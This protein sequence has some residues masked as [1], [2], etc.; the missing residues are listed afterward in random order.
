MACR[1][2]PVL[3][4]RRSRLGALALLAM[5]AACGGGK[6]DKSDANLSSLDAR[7][8]N[9]AGSFSPSSQPQR[10][11]TGPA[12]TLGSLALSQRADTDKDDNPSAVRT[13]GGCASQVRYGDQWAR[14]MPAAFAVYPGGH[15]VE[16]AGVDNG[17]CALRI[18]TFTT[19]AAPGTVLDH[20]RA[21]LR[22][23]GYDA[24]HRLC[25]GEH[26]MG[27]TRSADGAAYMLYAR[28]TAAGVTEVDIVTGKG[29]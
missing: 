19:A 5:L 25:R 20:Y 22:A 8:T 27:G 16:A 17:R 13:G 4:S 12:R 15:I 28:R 1:S 3:L 2:E 6:S 18:V 11:D 29:A 7:L 14:A 10:D 26:Q 24:E 9:S 23:A 21:Q